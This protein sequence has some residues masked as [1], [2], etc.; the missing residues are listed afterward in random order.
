MAGVSGLLRKLIA[1]SNTRKTRLHDELGN[2]ISLARLARNG[3]RAGLGSLPAKLGYRAVRPW[4]S[5][6]AQAGI[7]RF[8]DGKKRVLE[9]GSG[10]STVWYAEHAGEVVSIED[11][12]PWFEQVSGIIAARGADNVRYRFAEAADY[13]VLCAAERGGGFDLIMIDGSQRE[14]C[15]RLAIELVRPGGM[16]YLD[17]SDKAFGPDTGDIPAARRLLLDFA[18][19]D[20]AEVTRFTDF[21]P[22]QLFVQEGLMVRRLAKPGGAA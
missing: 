17:N 5:Y 18:V 9:F 16:I 7:A 2:R 1:G 21:A 20:C 11:Y 19:R 12:R 10:M 6:D 13:A 4:I 15:A 3:P 8:L 14:A 22:T